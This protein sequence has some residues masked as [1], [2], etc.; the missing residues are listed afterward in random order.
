MTHHYHSIA[1]SF[2]SIVFDYHGLGKRVLLNT[3]QPV[4]TGGHGC[5]VRFAVAIEKGFPDVTVEECL[6]AETTVYLEDRPIVS[7][8]TPHEVPFGERIEYSTVADRYTAA[9]RACFLEFIKDALAGE[10]DEAGA[11]LPAAVE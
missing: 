3:V 1:P 4:G 2:S 11:P 9:Y 10:A 6:S 7:K 5:I 8:L